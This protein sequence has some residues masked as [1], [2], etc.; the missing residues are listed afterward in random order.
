MHDNKCGSHLLLMRAKSEKISTKFQFLINITCVTSMTWISQKN[1]LP[2]DICI[3]PV[4]DETLLLTDAG[5]PIIV[6]S[7]EAYHCESSLK[8]F[9]S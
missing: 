3:L 5:R 7:K 9:R 8:I 6:R 1:R 4:F 2:Y